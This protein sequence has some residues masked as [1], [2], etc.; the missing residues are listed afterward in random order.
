MVTSRRPT[1]SVLP[2]A[3]ALAV[4]IAITSGAE[5]R[6]ESGATRTAARATGAAERVQ[7]ARPAEQPVLAV[8]SIGTQRIS[9]Y[10]PD[11]LITRAP[12]STGQAGHPTPTGVFSVIQKNRWHRSNIYSGAPMPYMQRLTWSGIAM[13]EGNLPGY[14][15]SHGCIRLPGAFARELFS[16][17]KMGMRVIVTFSDATPAPFTH[18]SLPQPLL[19]AASAEAQRIASAGG[20]VVVPAALLS[21]PERLLNPIERGRLAKLEAQDAVQRAAK[22]VEEALSAAAFAAAAANRATQTVEDAAAAVADAETQLRTAIAAKLSA[23]GD[24]QAAAAERVQ[25]AEDHL[26]EALR[27]QAEAKREA[28]AAFPASFDAVKAVRAAEAAHEAAQ[29]ALKDANRRTEHV[30]V[31]VSRKERRVFVRQGFTPVF[32]EPIEIRDPEQ[33]L[34]THLLLAAEAK[35]D[36]RGLEWLATTV[37]DSSLGL[38]DRSSR[39]GRAEDVRPHVQAGTLTAAAALERIEWPQETRRLIAER[40]WAGGS[41]VISDHGLGTE[42]GLGTDFIVQTR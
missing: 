20:A 38:D 22:A 12:V 26:A 28:D 36:G 15:A 21:A 27:I 4:L 18:A 11:G 16:T 35:E 25:D 8:I 1:T 40:L 37:P 34:G 41:I 14:P 5:A 6:Q 31:L 39:K 10:G 13:H 7:P 24:A 9:V 2:L 33:P 30:S 32:D 29:A 17:T 19:V 42:T 3:S 23:T